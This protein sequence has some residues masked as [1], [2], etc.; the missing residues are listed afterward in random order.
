MC[1]GNS[2][3]PAVSEPKQG[4]ARDLG[5]LPSAPLHDQPLGLAEVSSGVG[6]ILPAPHGEQQ[7]HI[8]F[9]RSQSG[10]RHKQVLQEPPNGAPGH[11]RI[12]EGVAAPLY[13]QLQQQ[14]QQPQQQQQQQLP[15]PSPLPPLQPPQ[16][17]PQQPVGEQAQLDSVCCA[18]IMQSSSDS[19]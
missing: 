6:L 2:T 15:P 10:N 12:Y 7:Y 14:Q 19:Q 18:S 11:G 8:R 1:A 4:A 9:K 5:S 16:Q 13:P 17:L 3:S